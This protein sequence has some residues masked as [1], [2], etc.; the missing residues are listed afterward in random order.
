MRHNLVNARKEAHLTQTDVAN[1]IGIISQ[2]YQKIEY[3]ERIGSVKIWDNLEDLFN[4]PQRFL[5]ENF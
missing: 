4:K 1:K 3:G 5:Q 2:Y